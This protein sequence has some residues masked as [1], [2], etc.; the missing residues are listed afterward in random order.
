M[1][2]RIDEVSLLLVDLSI[3]EA[4]TVQ[5]EPG[6]LQMFYGGLGLNTWLLYN[7]TGPGTDPLGP[8]NIVLFSPGLL[9]GSSAPTSTRVEV[10]TKSPLTGLI[11]TGNAGGHWGP[12][13]RRS[14]IG[15]IMVKGISS[16]PVIL[17][18]NEGD[19][20]FKPAKE[21]WGLDTYTVTDKL[22]GELGS[23]YSV[24]AIGQAGENLVRFSAPVFDKQH[25]PGRCHAGAVLGSKKLK[26]IAVKGSANLEPHDPKGYEDAVAYCESRVRD[27][28][29]W[30]ARLKAGSM[31]TIAVTSE[32]VNY[33]EEAA[34]FLKR[35][36]PGVY[37]PCIVEPLYGCILQTDIREGPYTGTEVT[38]AGLTL[39]SG[40][41]SRYSISLPAAY[42][43]NELCQRYGMDMFGPFSYAINLYEKGVITMKETGLELALGNE[44]ALMRLIEM[45]ARREGF[46][47]LLAGGSVAM[48]EALG[49]E[50]LK[51]VKAVKGLELMFRDPQRALKGKVF[52][53][54]SILTNPRGGDDLKG[55]HAVSNYPGL[56]GWARKQGVSLEDHSKWLMGWLDMPK[57]FKEKVFGDPPNISE[58]DQ[59]LMTIWYNDLTSAYNSLG[60]CMFASSGVE[61]L[62]PTSMARLYSAATGVKTT[63]EDIM[64][65]GERV[66]NLMRLYIIREGVSKEDDMWP[67]ALY[68]ET[69]VEGSAFSVEEAENIIGRYY[70]LRG[71]DVET[72]KPLPETLRRLGLP[73]SAS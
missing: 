9:T 30:K 35:G 15:S 24:M 21:L 52:T 47:D 34:P 54:L 25:M 69:P 23:E 42:H 37:C 10:T 4:N 51:H 67:S 55:T 68:E 45:V 73:T 66:F 3:E 56:S 29:G 1:V 5:I 65:L 26:A 14:G 33:E 58:P 71:W 8:D 63:V 64:R 39:Y 22:V 11:G 32:G 46:G 72:G 20:S 17:V 31:G 36:E 60:L 61:A 41:A 49:G 27:F 2:L 50:A 7:H 19:I 59:V 57:G 62:G 44:E 18:I 70:R 43:V 28:P 40:T 53:A 13:L 38:C 12:R 48:A 6:V 16:Y